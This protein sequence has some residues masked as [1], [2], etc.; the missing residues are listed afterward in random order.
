VEFRK[1][2][3]W[4]SGLAIKISESDTV[5]VQGT[6]FFGRMQLAWMID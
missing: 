2:R 6:E 5:E 3:T 1:I 4:R